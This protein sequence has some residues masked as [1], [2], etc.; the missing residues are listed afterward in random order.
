VAGLF[1]GEVTI[2]ATP[3]RCGVGEGVI[4]DRPAVIRLP[5]HICFGP[6]AT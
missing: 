1:Q 3:N 6:K 5:D 2:E 4:F